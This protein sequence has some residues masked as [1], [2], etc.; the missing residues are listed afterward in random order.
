VQFVVRGVRSSAC[1]LVGYEP[2]VRFGVF[3]F[4]WVCGLECEVW[5]GVRFGV[6]VLVRVIL[7]CAV[8]C[9]CAVCAV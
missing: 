3:R 1:G 2:C 4:G 7:V 5:F 6:C 8:W 9:V